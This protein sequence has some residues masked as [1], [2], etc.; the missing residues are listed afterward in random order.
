[1][2]TEADYGAWERMRRRRWERQ[3]HGE[4]LLGGGLITKFEAAKPFPYFALGARASYVPI[5]ALYE[6]YALA[7]FGDVAAGFGRVA[8]L[9]GSV[10]IQAGYAF[11]PLTLY[12]VG[13]G[14]GD[15]VAYMAPDDDESPPG[16]A[17]PLARGALHLGYGVRAELRSENNRHAFAL[18]ARRNHRFEHLLPRSNA[19]DA[20]VRYD[21]LVVGLRWESYRDVF[22]GGSATSPWSLTLLTGIGFDMSSPATA[23]E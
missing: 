7:L 14:G 11:G 5:F 19:V 12:G 16:P 8:P 18:T 2:M 21:A 10:G 6:P 13:A 9:R 17:V 3:L 20:L 15:G 4:V 22:V 23:Q 1:M